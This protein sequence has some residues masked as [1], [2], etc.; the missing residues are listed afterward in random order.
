MLFK[1]VEPAT[2]SKRPVAS[3]KPDVRLIA[4][5]PAASEKRSA[6][7]RLHLVMDRESFMRLRRLKAQVEALSEAEVVRWALKAYEIFEPDD[8]STN[9]PVGPNPGT[10]HRGDVEHLCIRIQHEMKARLDVEHEASGR[11][12]SEQVRRALRVLSQLVRKAEKL[13]GKVAKMPILPLSQDRD[14]NLDATL[15]SMLASPIPPAPPT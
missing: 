12:Y 7:Y 13:K 1:E 3:D 9:D 8:E 11:S 2:R 5:R 15:M 4:S 10:F 14:M 6:E